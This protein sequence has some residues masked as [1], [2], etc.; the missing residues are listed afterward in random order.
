MSLRRGIIFVD[1]SAPDAAL[2]E[3]GHAIGL[4]T[5]KEQ[6]DQYPPAGLPVEGL[7]A[8]INDASS[9]INGFRGRILHF[10]RKIDTW[11]EEKYWYDI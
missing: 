8:F 1:E 4:Y 11:Y 5:S 7:T 9:S 6:Y 3:M 2:H 10:P